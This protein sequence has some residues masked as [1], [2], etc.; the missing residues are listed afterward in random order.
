MN[1][2][3]YVVHYLHTGWWAGGWWA[4]VAASGGWPHQ[5]KSWD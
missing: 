2:L 3:L 1:Q 5:I 4:A